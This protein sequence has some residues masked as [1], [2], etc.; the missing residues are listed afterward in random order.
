VREFG[1]KRPV[2]DKAGEIVGMQ[3]SPVTAVTREVLGAASLADSERRLV[4]SLEAGD[5]IS[6]RPLGTRRVYRITA[7]DVF[8][9]VLRCEANR[10]TLERARDRKAKKADRLA[11]QR[12]ERAEKRLFKGAIPS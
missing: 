6:I 11:R 10:L 3:E 2:R 7:K 9:Y 8:H 4:V 5:L 12:Q 1:H